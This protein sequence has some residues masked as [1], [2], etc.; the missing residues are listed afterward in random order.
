MEMA[1]RGKPALPGLVVLLLVSQYLVFFLKPQ[2]LEASN[3]RK[4]HQ[5]PCKNAA[6]V[7]GEELES[8]S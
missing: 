3:E 5:L 8:L 6:V 2:L 4:I 1:Q 7:M